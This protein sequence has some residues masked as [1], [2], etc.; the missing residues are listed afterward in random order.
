MNWIE[1]LLIIGG[2]SLDIFA[3]ME[4]QGSLVAKIEK[5]GLAF[6]CGFVCLWQTAAFGAGMFLILFLS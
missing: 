1:N 2:V 4:S 5:R 6:I 3:T